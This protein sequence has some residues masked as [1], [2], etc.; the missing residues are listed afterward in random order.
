[1]GQPPPHPQLLTIK[2]CS[3]EKVLKGKK[4]LYNPPYPSRWSVGPGQPHVLAVW[5]HPEGGSDKA[6]GVM[7]E[8]MEAENRNKPMTARHK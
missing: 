1:M 2:E 8:G 7:E 4:S 6:E 5:E 3:R